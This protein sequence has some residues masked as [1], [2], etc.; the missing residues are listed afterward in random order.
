MGN[1]KK[2][3]FKFKL[4]C[5]TQ[6]DEHYCSANHQVMSSGL[7]IPNSGPGIEYISTMGGSG[8][9]FRINDSQRLGF[10]HET[11]SFYYLFV[12]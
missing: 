5:V 10:T 11:G 12:L 8:E 9:R 2:H 7:A 6:V 1:K 4:S 3:S